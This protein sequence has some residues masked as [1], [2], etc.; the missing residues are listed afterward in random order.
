MVHSKYPHTKPIIFLILVQREHDTVTKWI[1]ENWLFPF[2]ESPN[3]AFAMCIARH[4][5]WPDTLE[6]IGFP[7]SWDPERVRFILKERRLVDKKKV[8]TSAY[9]IS[10]GGLAMDK[11]DYSVDHVLTPLYAS[12]RCPGDHECVQ[13]YWVHLQTHTGFASFMAG[14]VVA[15]LK[16]ISPLK[17]APDWHSWAP[18]GPGSIR[19]L[20][21]YHNRLTK[22]SMRQDQGVAE[23][24]EIQRKIY[25]C[26]GKD[27]PL[28]N[29]QNC[30][31]EF[32]KYIRLKYENGKVRA[33]YNGR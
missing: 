13:S 22:K 23:L 11:I 25:I 30:M 4:F 32:D 14:Q 16:F 31:C 3:I 6:A 17:N 27:L 12:L 15:D 9:T 20:N 29:V 21:R 33:K 24:L 19:G 1:F 2:A 26:T 18:L 28:H 8:Y 5:N 7:H 10:T